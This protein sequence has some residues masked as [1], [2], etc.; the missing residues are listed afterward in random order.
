VEQEA[1]DAGN[2]LEAARWAGLAGCQIGDLGNAA[3]A[4]A[5]RVNYLLV[6]DR[7]D[8]ALAES[9]TAFSMSPITEMEPAIEAVVKA[10]E[11][12]DGAVVPRVKGF[13]DYQRLGPAGQDGEKGTEDDLE[14]PLAD[15]PFGNVPQDEFI[16]ELMAEAGIMECTIHGHGYL[17]LGRPEAA[18]AE[19]RAAY[20][21]ASGREL[22]QAT[23]GV[24]TA[25]KA[26][27]GHAHRANW[28]LSYHKH[29]PSGPDGE[30]GSDDDLIDPLA[31]EPWN[32]APERASALEE[33]IKACPG[34]YEGL[35][36]KGYLLMIAGKPREALRVLVKAYRVRPPGGGDLA[37]AV[38]DVAVAIKAVDGHVRRANQYL[39]YRKYGPA[40][41]DGKAGTLDDIADPTAD[42]LAQG[43]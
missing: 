36:R 30:P 28:Y 7:I 21:I 29:G 23:Y 22:T 1:V 3:E 17:A 35:R 34:N 27:D 31:D 18:L 6:E 15:V 40:G 41:P 10:F 9:R 2:Y 26:M 14:N 25:I 33:A 16:E 13:L 12:A 43:D 32:L 4:R 5:R 42:I 38:T 20:A 39:E 8:Q 19:L 37:Q 11:A 24:A